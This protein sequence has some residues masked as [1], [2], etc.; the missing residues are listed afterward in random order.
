MSIDLPIS[1]HIHKQIFIICS[2]LSLCKKKKKW[3]E[4]Y[5]ITWLSVSLCS[6]PSQLFD[7][8]TSLYG[9]NIMAPEPISV[10][11]FINPFHKSV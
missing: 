1:S 2:L 8:S 10:V 3:K 4:A 11:Y 5:E 9:M 7:A 6:P